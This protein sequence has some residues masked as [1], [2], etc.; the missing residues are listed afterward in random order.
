ML[1][2]TLWNLE[3]KG[4]ALDQLQA[5]LNDK[6]SEVKDLSEQLQAALSA[7]D[8]TTALLADTKRRH[9]ALLEDREGL[10]AAHQGQMA[11]MMAELRK[12]QE[13]I[14]GLEAEVPALRPG[15]P[16]RGVCVCVCV[17]GTDQVARRTERRAAADLGPGSLSVCSMLCCSTRGYIG[18][19]CSG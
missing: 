6:T 4:A 1:K 7:Q 3:S 18:H 9:E 12:R 14:K 8:R 2:E 5:E 10:E 11:E 15:H 16:Q 17:C 13:R 19:R